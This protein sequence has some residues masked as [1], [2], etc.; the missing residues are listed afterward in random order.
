MAGVNNFRV[1]VLGN[2]PDIRPAPNAT[3]SVLTAIATSSTLR[4]TDG[5]GFQV[6]FQQQAGIAVNEEGTVFVISGGG[7]GGPGK[8]PSAMFS[9]I[10]CFED[11][12]P[13]DRR[14]DFVD[15]R[16]DTLPN[17]PASGLPNQ[18][19]GDSDRFDHIFYQ[20]PIDAITL[21]PTGLSGLATGFLRYTN[22]LAPSPIGPGVA[23]G[24]TIRVLGDDSTTDPLPADLTNDTGTVV[25][26]F[27]DPGHQVAGGDDQN[28]PFTGDDSD[29]VVVPAGFIVPPFN[30]LVDTYPD[31]RPAVP[32]LQSGGFEFVFGADTSS[33][34]GVL[35]DPAGL[36][37]RAAIW[38]DHDHSGVRISGRSGGLPDLRVPDN[39]AQLSRAEGSR[40]VRQ[41]PDHAGRG[42]ADLHGNPRAVRHAGAELRGRGGGGIRQRR[43]RASGLLRPSVERV[44]LEL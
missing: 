26:E 9:E 37:S 10:L 12:C 31:G 34:T 4:I 42:I 22:R 36:D 2:G 11:M 41:R 43:E 20:A 27:L 8:N 17:P 1:F 40:E 5:V 24:T 33:I 35:A 32:G 15:L 16:G 29:T 38:D 14:A 3:P 30:V 7:S 28:T 19:D 25:F 44:L 23:L 13:M 18:G 39:R 6:D 21:T